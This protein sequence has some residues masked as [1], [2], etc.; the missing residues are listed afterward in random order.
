MPRGGLSAAVSAQGSQ[1]LG[2]LSTQRDKLPL[3][4]T[5]VH[6]RALSGSSQHAPRPVTQFAAGD[7]LDRG[8]VGVED[9]MSAD[10][11]SQPPM[12]R[13]IRLEHGGTGAGM[14][15]PRR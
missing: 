6:P 11:Q 12:A 13:W 3:R 4:S 14:P 10:V 5:S 9:F 7:E 8:V 1:V 2:W 15:G